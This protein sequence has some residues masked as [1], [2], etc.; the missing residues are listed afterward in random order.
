[1]NFVVSASTLLKHLKAISGVL[2]TNNTV[3]ILD[4]FL[5]EIEK[6]ELTVSASDME[7]AITSSIKVESSQGHVRQDKTRDGGAI[8]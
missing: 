8:T 4:C 1:M 3:P 5:F 7:T 6:G 2:S